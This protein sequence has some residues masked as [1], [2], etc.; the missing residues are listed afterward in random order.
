MMRDS[1]MRVVGISVGSSVSSK[2][3]IPLQQHEDSAECRGNE[4]DV[5]W[6][7]HA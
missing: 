1:E 7:N 6:N 5:L 3:S 4:K 2:V